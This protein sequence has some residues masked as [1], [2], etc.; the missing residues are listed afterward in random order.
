MEVYNA[1]VELLKP[2]GFEKM[3]DGSLQRNS[4]GCG[5][6][7]TFLMSFQSVMDF[8]LEFPFYG[9]NDEQPRKQK[10]GGL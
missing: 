8:Q 4:T 3:A 7:I 1:I 2:H 5:F 6:S 9:K 10:E